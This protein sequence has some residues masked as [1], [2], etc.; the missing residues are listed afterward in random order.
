MNFLLILAVGLVMGCA[1][2][3]Q[4]YDPQKP[5]RT[6]DGFVNNYDNSPRP[7]VWKWRWERLWTNFPEDP[8]E[9]APTEK[10]SL[11]SLHLKRTR[12][13]TWFGQS[14]VLVQLQGVNVLTDPIFS[15]RASPVSFAGP[16][17]Y[18]DLPI[19]MNELP[20]IDVVV[21]SHNHYDHMDLPTLKALQMYGLG[22][23]RFLVPL[24]LKKL[25]EDEGLTNV[26]EFDWWESTVIGPLHLTFTPVQHWS[27]RSLWDQNLTLWGG[28]MISVPKFQVF[29]AGDSGYS[30]DFQDIYE[31]LGAPDLA[32]LPIGAYAPRWFMKHMH[33]DTAEAVKVH[34]DLHAKLSVPIHWGTFKLSDEP[35]LEPPEKLRDS[36]KKANL[37]ESVFHIMK[38]GETLLL[39]DNE[40]KNGLWYESV[41]N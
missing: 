16:K 31:R 6:K 12:A 40:L 18:G 37:S 29:F 32:L 7:S 3:F 4:Y 9:G 23:T 13:L 33:M 27:A 10:I 41:Q 24:G 21:I 14:S 11:G 20:H 36:I 19:E 8:P 26:T 22:K 28:W 1:G 17:R 38:R 5:H 30:K 34:Q 2:K 15:S 35:L 39:E 25:L